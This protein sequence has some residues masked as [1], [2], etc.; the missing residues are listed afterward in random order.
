MAK[1]LEWHEKTVAV[2]DLRPFER[3]PR[4]ITKQDYNKLLASLKKLGQF[5]PL[6]ATPDLRIIGGHQRI[7]A[8]Q[9]LGWQDVR[10]SI[11]SRD[12]TDA[13]FHEILIRSNVANGQWNMDILAADFEVQDLLD[14]GV[15]VDW[16]LPDNDAKEGGDG[17]SLE[18]LE[19]SNYKITCEFGSER[20]A[21]IFLDEM[22]QRKISAKA[23][24]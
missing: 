12:L 13:E 1:K 24:K 18:L 23:G 5:T 16:A 19:T 21:F 2:K 20:E 7:K 11:P 8:M 14:W 4:T 9:E 6:T 3:N 15:N 17:D 22:K 10:V